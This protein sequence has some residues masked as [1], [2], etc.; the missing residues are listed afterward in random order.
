MALALNQWSHRRA[1][2]NGS[3]VQYFVNG[4]LLNDGAKLPATITAQDGDI[5][6]G[7]SHN[8][9]SQFFNGSLDEVRIYNRI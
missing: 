5:V 1:V 7:R 3:Q 4:V 2:F 6:A 9:I 8:N